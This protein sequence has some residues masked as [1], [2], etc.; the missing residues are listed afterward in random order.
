MNDRSLNLSILIVSWNTR[1]LLCECLDSI[2]R[3]LDSSIKFETIVVDNASS[4][5]T[6]AAVHKMFPQ[7]KLIE[8]E[9]NLGFAPGVNQAAAE[10]AGRFLLLLNSDAKFLDGNFMEL[11]DAMTEDETIGIIG[12]S[13]IMEGNRK[14]WRCYSFPSFIHLVKNYSI[15]LIYRLG[16]HA[17][18][19]ARSCSVLADGRKFYEADWLNGAYLLVRR[20]LMNG[21][22]L[23]DNRIF[24]YFED[25]LLCRKAWDRGYRVVYLEAADVFH[26]GYA[27]SKQASL[28][29]TV[30]SYESSRV[31]IREMHGLRALI[32]YERVNRA[33]WLS[34]LPVFYLLGFLGF[35]ESAGKK[36]RIFRKL[37]SLP[38][39][40]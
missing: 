4:D 16:K 2:Y 10:A 25:A 14:T 35:K 22:E 21:T 1:D 17:P 28:Q 36:Y 27:S 18:L 26:V 20:E 24:M 5:G 37:L 34:F 8:N 12:G 11:M 9:Q 7:V 19:K 33:L 39:A 6:A 32:W 15:D 30:Y 3:L 38:P 40:T 29:S 13:V 23:L 31:Y